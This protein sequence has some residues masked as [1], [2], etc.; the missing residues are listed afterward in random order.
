M[1]QIC[2]SFGCFMW[3]SVVGTLY[4]ICILLHLP[5]SL[6]TS[7]LV[8]EGACAKCLNWSICRKQINQII[9]RFNTF[10]LESEFVIW[11]SIRPLPVCCVEASLTVF[12]HVMSSALNCLF[13][14]YKRTS[15]LKCSIHF[16]HLWFIHSTFLSVLDSLSKMFMLPLGRINRSIILSKYLS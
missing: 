4:H 13:V 12:H 5:V 6:T 3:R 14:G 1:D 11:S 15:L 8:Y 7:P 10:I 9:I 16:F 2:V